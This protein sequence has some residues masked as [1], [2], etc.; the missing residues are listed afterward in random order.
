MHL[1]HGLASYFWR[2]RKCKLVL[3]CL[4][5]HDRLAQMGVTCHMSHVMA[6]SWCQSDPRAGP[7]MK[8]DTVTCQPSFLSHW[9][10]FLTWLHVHGASCP[11]HPFQRLASCT[12]THIRACVKGRRGRVCWNAEQ[13]VAQMHA[14][15]IPS[16]RF[17]AFDGHDTWSTFSTGGYIMGYGAGNTRSLSNYA[18]GLGITFPAMTQQQTG[19]KPVPAKRVTAS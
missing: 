18:Q 19:S 11:S 13:L 17:T 10:P 12:F 8:R 15:Q 9:A 14:R 1:R 6:H 16:Q 3:V 7:G 5:E 2:S 4:S